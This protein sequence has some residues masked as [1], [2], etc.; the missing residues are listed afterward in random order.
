[1]KLYCIDIQRITYMSY[2]IYQVPRC[3]LRKR[4]DAGIRSRTTKRAD[5]RLKSAVRTLSCFHERTAK[6]ASVGQFHPHRIAARNETGNV[7]PDDILQFAFTAEGRTVQADNLP[8]SRIVHPDIGPFARFAAD[9]DEQRIRSRVREERQCALGQ[10]HALLRRYGRRRVLRE[11]LLKYLDR[12]V[13]DDT[14]S[15]QVGHRHRNIG[16]P[17][18]QAFDRQHGTADADRSHTLVVASRSI[19]QFVRRQVGGP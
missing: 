16:R 6:L 12:H 14:L 19:R 2:N 5:G 3:R 7:V 11:P 17:Q 1:M 4:T 18:L 13:L 8:C 15:G 10:F 9:A